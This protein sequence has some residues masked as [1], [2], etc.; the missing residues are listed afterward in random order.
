MQ[1]KGPKELRGACICDVEIFLEA[2]SRP[3]KQHS[4]LILVGSMH[5]QPQENICIPETLLSP[6]NYSQW[7]YIST[8]NSGF[9]HEKYILC[10]IGGENIFCKSVDL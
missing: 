10:D 5:L 8:N 4:K 2:F 9:W 7:K 3:N 1:F 6:R